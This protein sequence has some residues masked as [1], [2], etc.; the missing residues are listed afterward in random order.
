M[1]QGL[2]FDAVLAAV[3]SILELPP[4]DPSAAS[5]LWLKLS[6]ML[7]RMLGAAKI[8]ATRHRRLAKVLTPLRTAASGLTQSLINTKRGGPL[9]GDWVRFAERDLIALKDELL[10]L[11]EFMVE[12]ADF[13]R[14]AFLR[15]QLGELGGVNPEK[16]FEELHEAGAIS[17]RTWVLLMAQPN[18]W[19]EALKNRELSEQLAR[20]SG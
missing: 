20:I 3:E 19:R 8:D 15:A 14:F 7:D 18:S 12:E 10:A 11:R 9:R 4:K 13:L 17:E 5:S 1:E 6:P 16:L 2:T